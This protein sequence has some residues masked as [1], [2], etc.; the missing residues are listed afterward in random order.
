[1]CY[2]S[3]AKVMTGLQVQ[4][5]LAMS[6]SSCNYKFLSFNAGPRTCLG[7]EVALM[8]MKFGAVEIIQNYEMK[9][10][11]GQQI[12]PAPCVTLHMKRGLQVTVTKWSECLK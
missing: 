10:V 5:G 11:G 6:K 7:K 1:M 3:L 9:I 12:E 4:F 8:Q 2:M